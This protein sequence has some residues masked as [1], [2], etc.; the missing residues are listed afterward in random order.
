MRK[1]FFA[2]VALSVL[3]TGCSEKTPPL[4]RYIIPTTAPAGLATLRVK[5]P[6]LHNPGDVV[7]IVAI[8]GAKP[9]VRTIWDVDIPVAAGTRILD[10]KFMS[11]SSNAAEVST[12]RIEVE[13]KAGS[14][15]RIATQE[16]VRAF[17]MGGID[18][19]LKV[20]NETEKTQTYYTG[21]DAGK[22]LP[23][24]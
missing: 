17:G 11:R 20:I 18:W 3:M 19:Y 23:N 22:T 16:K 15:Y 2:L 10:L 12:I 13:M 4:P 6:F 24:K 8:D 14:I 1:S 5:E 9:E 7:E 21:P